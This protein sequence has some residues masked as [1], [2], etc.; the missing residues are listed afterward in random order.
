ML[1]GRDKELKILRESYKSDANSFAIV[2]GREGIGKTSLA[3][4]FVREL[5][6]I[7]YAVQDLSESE[8]VQSF[9][10]EQN[11]NADIKNIAESYYTC[12]KS[13][14]DSYENKKVVFIFDRFEYLFE[15]GV[16]FKAA[17]KKIY[18]EKEYDGR[19]MFLFLTDSVNF[20]EH[21]MA[22]LF[23]DIS[24]LT[25]K[26]I[27]LKEFNFL[28]L[29][30]MMPGESPEKIIYKSAMLGGVP[31][32]LEMWEGNKSTKENIK[33]LFLTKNGPLRL[34]AENTLKKD[35]RELPA[36]NA[37]LKTLAKGNWKLNDI[38]RRTGFSR[39]KISVYL[40]NLMELDIVCNVN[41]VEA[42]PKNDVKKGIYCIK[43]RFIAFWYRYVF[44][45]MSLLNAGKID[46]VYDK[47]IEPDLNDFIKEK[48]ADVCFEYM[49]LMGELGRLKG[50][51]SEWGRWFGKAGNIDVFGQDKWG[52]NV[53]AFCSFAKRKIDM[54]DYNKYIEI[55][56][57]ACIK[58]D[59]LFIFAA[60]GFSEDLKRI[61]ERE[62]INLINIDEL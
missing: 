3:F 45:N 49:Q 23:Y 33:K 62:N 26:T 43:D 29:M 47:Y 14:L 21:K 48:Y 16:G 7:Y 56:K 36:Y 25:D 52:H 6:F 13:V 37:I 5:P 60:S 30:D 10:E 42:G 28:E 58:C 27:K 41:S 1:V 44:P 35:L 61:K 2:Y 9:A 31:G 20:A 17:F 53:I 24:K 22:D 50:N 15:E 18:S 57:A 19:L 11:K 38:Y 12:I 32:L 55:L 8:Q 59:E 40:K 34:S 46:L 4:E 54:S 51:Y 39:A